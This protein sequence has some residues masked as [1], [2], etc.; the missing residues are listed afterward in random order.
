MKTR[1]FLTALT[2]LICSGTLLM[3]LKEDNAVPS[4]FN[5]VSPETEP[6]LNIG[7][8]LMQFGKSDQTVGEIQ[9]ANK[10]SD[11]VYGYPSN[12]I[13]HYDGVKLVSIYGTNMQSAEGTDE[14][15]NDAQKKLIMALEPGSLVKVLVDYQKAN[16]ATQEMEARTLDLAIQVKP[17]IEAEFGV[18]KDDVVMY[19][20]GECLN[21]AKSELEMNFEGTTIFFTVNENGSVQDVKFEASTGNEKVDKLIKE[22]LLNMPQWK[23][24]EL[25]NGTKVKQ[26]FQLFL[27]AQG[28]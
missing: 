12:W 5:F 13:K 10:L 1:K 20:N 21:T 17:D 18:R 3:A 27:G 14:I 28:C 19:L 15:L 11:F 7:F 4:D 26:T 22:S 23:P 24:A 25:A 2:I 16:P 8:T 9:K 6:E